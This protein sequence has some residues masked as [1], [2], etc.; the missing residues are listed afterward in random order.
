M[1]MPFIDS[2]TITK[3]N[4]IAVNKILTQNEIYPNDLEITLS[5]NVKSKSRVLF[6]VLP[7]KDVKED[8]IIK[9][10]IL[11]KRYI[12]AIFDRQYISSMR[13]SPDH[14]IFLSSLVQLQKLIYVYLCYEFGLS[15]NLEGDEKIKIWP[16][17]LNINMPKMITKNKN[18]SQKIFINSLRKTGKKTY[19]GKCE[20]TIDGI[21]KISAD[22][23]VYII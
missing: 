8:I 17:N 18:I 23:L 13:Q 7:N 22:A 5:D 21:V 4:Y 9:K 11:K 10:Y 20:S 2:L 16:T 3:D 19:F 14:L 15:I 1:K 12:E 6:N